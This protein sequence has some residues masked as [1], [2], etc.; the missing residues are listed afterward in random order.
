VAGWACGFKVAWI[1]EQGNKA[2]RT[3]RA[4]ALA[5]P[6]SAH[7]HTTSAVVRLGAAPVST[8]PSG[9]PPCPVPALSLPDLARICRQS[10]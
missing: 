9:D 1:A 2:S 8:H 7:Q 5:R 6:P 3:P 10:N 4:P